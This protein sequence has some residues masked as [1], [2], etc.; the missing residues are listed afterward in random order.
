MSYS[1]G[2]VLSMFGISTGNSSANSLIL[3]YKI[4]NLLSSLANVLFSV[5]RGISS[6]SYLTKILFNLRSFSAL[7]LRSLPKASRDFMVSN[8]RVLFS[9]LP[10]SKMPLK[11]KKNTIITTTATNC[12]LFKMVNF[13]PGILLCQ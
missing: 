4:K 6:F 12:L 10:A 8:S 13:N 2:H 1:S 9:L 5:K 3:R 11:R 7:I